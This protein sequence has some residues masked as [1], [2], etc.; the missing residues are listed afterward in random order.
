MMSA[1]RNIMAREGISA[2]YRGCSAALLR[3]FPANAGLFFGYEMV[4]EDLDLKQCDFLL[5][6]QRMLF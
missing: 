2:F 6:A 5:Q 1:A 3:A 4:S